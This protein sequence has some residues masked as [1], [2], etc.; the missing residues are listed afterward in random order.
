MQSCQ[1][2]SEK[3]NGS[4]TQLTAHMISYYLISCT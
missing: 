3:E 1:V 4:R 2:S